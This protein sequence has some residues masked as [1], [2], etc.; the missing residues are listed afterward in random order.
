[1]TIQHNCKTR[2]CYVVKHMPDWAIFNECFP[3]GIRIGDVDGM[4]EIN[5]FVIWFEWKGRTSE[6][7]NAQRMAF[8][9]AS[10]FA[11]RQVWIVIWGDKGTPERI[12][13]I[14]DGWAK[15]FKADLGS[16]RN[17]IQRWAHYADFAGSNV[18][19]IAQRRRS[20]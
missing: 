8:T 1:M 4:I 13:F 2:G 5:G 3:R 15:R 18:V 16:L 9:H 14:K 11:P 17:L 19:P 7:S 6:L 20:P 10:K 12:L